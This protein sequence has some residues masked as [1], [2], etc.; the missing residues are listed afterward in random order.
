MGHGTC[1]RHC[2]I[3]SMTMNLE[4]IPYTDAHTHYRYPKGDAVHF[5]RNAYLLQHPEKLNYNVCCGIHPWFVTPNW[6]NQLEQLAHIAKQ[7]NVVAIGECGLDYL[8]PID[9]TLQQLAFEAQVKLAIE[10]QK[11]L[12]LHIVKAWH[13]LPPFL[14]AANTPVILHGY[15]GNPEQTKQLLK[16]T[17]LFS[18]GTRQL[19]NPEKLKQLLQ[20]IPLE[21]LLFETDTHRIGLPSLFAQ[22]AAIYGLDE[23]VL[24]KQVFRNFAA[25]FKNT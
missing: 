13:D 10:L 6:T 23:V 2:P 20:H 8:K 5:V 4:R 24:R 18:I 12:L 3:T 1:C 16:Y 22:A 14:S 21:R 15:H 25:T 9:R 7:N 11:P 19:H 17:T